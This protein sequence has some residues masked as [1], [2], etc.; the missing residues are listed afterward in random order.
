VGSELSP[1]TPLESENDRLSLVGSWPWT[2]R[3]V[4]DVVLDFCSYRAAAAARVSLFD[5]QPVQLLPPLERWRFPS[6]W[7]PLRSAAT[8]TTR[9]YFVVRWADS[10]TLSLPGTALQEKWYSP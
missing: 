1:T 5:P 7:F 4:P 9:T 3:P 2:C 10:A 8:P 6:G